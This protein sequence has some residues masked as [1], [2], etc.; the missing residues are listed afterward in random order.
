MTADRDEGDAALLE[1]LTTAKKLLQ[2][3]VAEAD[4]EPGVAAAACAELA[5]ECA[6]LFA[7][8]RGLAPGPVLDEVARL[9]RRRGAAVHHALARTPPSATGGM[10]R[11]LAG[12]GID[13]RRGRGRELEG[14]MQAATDAIRPVGNA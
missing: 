9:T 11:G 4:M 3:A 13:G 1:R 5:G 2:R 10:R 7:A 14:R 8:E 6:A 12:P